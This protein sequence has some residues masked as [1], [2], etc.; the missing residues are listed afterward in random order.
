[1]NKCKVKD[2]YKKKNSEKG[3]VNN[4]IEE[5]IHEELFIANVQ[6]KI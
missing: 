4:V 3:A 2:F 6:T 1:M 5:I